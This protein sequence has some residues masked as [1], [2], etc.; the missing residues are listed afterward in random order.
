MFIIFIIGVALGVIMV[1][2][3]VEVLVLGKKEIIIKKRGMSKSGYSF[4]MINKIMPHI[5]IYT[6]LTS[7]L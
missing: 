2:V 4:F 7:A 3:S 1:E 5:A 6:S